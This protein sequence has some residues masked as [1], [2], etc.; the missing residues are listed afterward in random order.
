MRLKFCWYNLD[1]RTK[2]YI[3]KIITKAYFWKKKLGK[4]ITTGTTNHLYL[5]NINY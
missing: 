5:K 1:I 3:Y 4:V 2:M